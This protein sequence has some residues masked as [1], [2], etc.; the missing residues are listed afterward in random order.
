MSKQKWERRE[1]KKKNKNKMI[2]TGKSVKILANYLEFRIKPIKKKK[3]K[4]KN[5]IR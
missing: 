4:K 2:V 1:K 5:A 3:R